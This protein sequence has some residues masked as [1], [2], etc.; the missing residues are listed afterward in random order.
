MNEKRLRLAVLLS[1][2]G[3]TMV[4]LHEHI[5]EQHLNA[6]IDI[7]I[8]SRADVAGVERAKQCGLPI[9]LIERKK[10]S[11]ADF[12]AEITEAVQSVD[13]VC[14]AGFLSLWHIPENFLGR[15][16]NIHPALLPAFG[17]QGMFG[18]RVHEAVIA[19]GKKVSGCTVHFCDNEYDHGP[20]VLQRKVD[21][22]TDDT[23]ETLAGKVFE[24]E[25]IA[26]PEA[27]RLF[28]EQRIRLADGRVDILPE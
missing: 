20:I 10:L 8:S 16:M 13:L 18:H 12:Q 14:M 5:R 22:S 19:A 6:Q 24:Q 25:C 4:N 26:Y 1:G 27:V 2:G 9:I 28:C 15:V 21:V 23:V 7:V 11:S 17:G 3:R